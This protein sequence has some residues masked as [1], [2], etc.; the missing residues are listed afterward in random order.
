[1]M[2]APPTDSTPVKCGVCG[3]HLCWAEGCYVQPAPC[4]CGWQTTVEAVG[5]RARQSVNLPSGPI[6]VKQTT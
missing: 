4:S 1:M 5:R 2:S 3:K 6:E